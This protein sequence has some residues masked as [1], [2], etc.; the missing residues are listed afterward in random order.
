MLQAF[1]SRDCV[2]APNVLDQQDS[3]SFLKDLGVRP[4]QAE[5]RVTRND[6]LVMEYI[7][8]IALATQTGHGLNYDVNVDAFDEHVLDE[9]IYA[10]KRL[11]LGLQRAN[12]R[13]LEHN[14]PMPPNIIFTYRDRSI[15]AMLVDFEIAEDRRAVSPEYVRNTVA[16]LYSERSVPRSKDAT[17]YEL[18]LDMHLLGKSIEAMELIRDTVAS[19]T[20]NSVWDAVNLRL[21]L[22]GGASLNLGRAFRYIRSRLS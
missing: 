12:A 20:R 19:A 6:L 11:R 7:P 2:F 10:L 15:E 21:P 9:M 1:R 13:D 14:D 16:E 4:S 3:V 8:G 5:L 17:K 18:N 22:V